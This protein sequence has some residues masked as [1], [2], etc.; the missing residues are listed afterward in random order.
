MP[1]YDVAIIGGGLWGEISAVLLSR[2]GYSVLLCEARDKLGGKCRIDKIH[3]VSIPYFFPCLGIQNVIQTYLDR[4][5]VKVHLSEPILE[6]QVTPSDLVETVGRKFSARAYLMAIAYPSLRSLLGAH[7]HQG[8]ATKLRQREMMSC[9]KIDFILKSA[10]SDFKNLIF[11]LENNGIGLF[12][13]NVDRSFIPSPKQ[14]SQWLYFLSEKEVHD[15][16]E[17]I[18][19]VRVAKRKLKK[20]F[21]D[22]FEITEWERIGVAVDFLPYKREP[23]HRAKWTNLKNVFWTDVELS[24]YDPACRHQW[25]DEL[26]LEI[27]RVENY[28]KSS[29]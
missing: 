21:P 1:T 19:K 23:L 12:T 25:F 17:M 16:D 7:I 6:C 5:N 15:K 3:G 27:E 22:F 2:K 9:L 18:K 20:M 29:S 4:P 28:L 14:L 10:I 8:L 26:A 13:S 24:F 11:D